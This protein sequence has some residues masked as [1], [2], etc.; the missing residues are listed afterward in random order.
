MNRSPYSI[1]QWIKS[2]NNISEMI[3]MDENLDHTAATILEVLNVHLG[4]FAA[5]FLLVDERKENLV[6][7][8]FTND[9]MVGRALK[10]IPFDVFKIKYPLNDPKK[11]T[12]I[13]RCITENKII[14]AKTLVEFFHPIV[15]PAMLLNQTQKIIG[16]RNC[17]AAPVRM[18]NEPIGVFFVVTQ[19]T[20]FTEDEL[21]LL[22][23]YANMSGITRENHARLKQ[24]AE[25][26]EIEKETTSLLSHEIK[27]PIAIAYNNAELLNMLLKKNEQKLGPL[28]KDFKKI[29][30]KLKNGL[31]HIKELSQSILNLRSIENNVEIANQKIDVK[32]F[33]PQV[34]K[35]FQKLARAKGIKLQSNYE[36]A[37]GTFYGGGA[38]FE[39]VVTILL[40]NAVK[41]TAEGHIKVD[42]KMNGENLSCTI[43][44]TGVGISK[45]E[46]AKIFDRYYR[47]K[48][49][50]PGGGYVHGL[51]LGLYIAK[52]S[53]DALNGEIKIQDR[54]EGKG[55]EF[56]VSIP[57]Y[58]G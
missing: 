45:K 15:R 46:R 58:K 13:A 56:V 50:A 32:R 44:D 38:Q 12:G 31:E 10:A 30:T 47:V 24:L 17:V 25:K 39:E 9:K 14:Q 18:R 36:I 52:R 26:Y 28:F 1:H 19:Q 3:L 51:G 41:Y 27:T 33:L 4:A 2:L 40:D 22:Q 7:Q 57:V 49:A 5:V 42:V 53:I 20:Q 29:E 6:L 21:E 48:N 11:I 43:S 55:V 34:I 35:N 54:K 16:L 37:G 23:F 8:S